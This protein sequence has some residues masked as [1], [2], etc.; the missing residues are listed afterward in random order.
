MDDIEILSQR[1]IML[2]KGKI[3]MNGSIGEVRSS[4]PSERRL[5]VHLRSDRQ[6]ID[7]P[8]A[9]LVSV[10]PHKAVFKFDPGVISTPGLISRI[11]AKYD[12]SD[13]FIENQPIDEI[14]AKVYQAH[15]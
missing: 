8:E 7:D 15:G 5:V 12:I 10:T 4:V 2:N 9:E 1:V 3:V 6:D 13:I 11:T 14:I